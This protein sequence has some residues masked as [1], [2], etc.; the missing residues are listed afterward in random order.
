MNYIRTSKLIK[1]KITMSKTAD[2]QII[3]HDIHEPSC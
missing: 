1:N 3:I 2:L